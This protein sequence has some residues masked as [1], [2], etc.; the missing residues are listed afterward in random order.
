V[1]R[2]RDD[3][4]KDA[5]KGRNLWYGDGPFWRRRRSYGADEV[6]I[7]GEHVPNSCAPWGRAKGNKQPESHASTSIVV[8]AVLSSRFL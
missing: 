6:K 7:I 2:E 5:A 8:A 4:K 3:E 1:E